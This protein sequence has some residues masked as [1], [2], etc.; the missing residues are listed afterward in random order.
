[1]AARALEGTTLGEKD[2][3]PPLMSLGTRLSI[4]GEV[5]LL[6]PVT[7]EDDLA[8]SSKITEDSSK[9]AGDSSEVAGEVEIVTD[10]RVPQEESAEVVGSDRR[11]ESMEVVESDRKEESTEVVENDRKEE[12]TEVVEN[13]RKEESAEVVEKDRSDE[14]GEEERTMGVASVE[15]VESKGVSANQSPSPSQH[16]QES[17]SE[18]SERSDL[19]EV[20][21]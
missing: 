6:K 13:D 15:G 12:S 10:L 20:D 9:V 17:E 5:D 16:D 21:F 2:L 3:D 19:F 11:E 14:Q 18:G 7:E 1:V 4:R 8:R